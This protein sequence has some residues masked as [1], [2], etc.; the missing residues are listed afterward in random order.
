MDYKLFLYRQ[1]FCKQR[2]PEIGKKVKQMLSNPLRL[3]FC[4]LR[5]I[6]ILHYVIIYN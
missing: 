3:N 2:Q 1:Q 6:Q 4:Y 5:I